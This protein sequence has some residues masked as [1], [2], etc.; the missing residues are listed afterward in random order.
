MT[1]GGIDELMKRVEDRHE[2]Y[3][4]EKDIDLHKRDVKDMKDA[5]RHSIFEK[6][7]SKRIWE[8]LYKV[9]DSSDVLL[10]VLDAR[11]PEGTRNKA[12]E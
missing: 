5:T 7:L 8:E 2:A 3:S 11:N 1:V 10:F 4:T 6:G 12:L 9:I